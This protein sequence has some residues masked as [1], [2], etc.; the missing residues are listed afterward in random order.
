M[1]KCLKLLRLSIQTTEK[2][3]MPNVTFDSKYVV[4]GARDI[5]PEVSRPIFH[6]SDWLVATSMLPEQL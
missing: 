1:W 2:L 5:R 6:L 4:F 3:F